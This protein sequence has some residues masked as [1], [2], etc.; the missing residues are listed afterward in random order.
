[1]PGFS[2]DAIGV[3][4]GVYLNGHVLEVSS[5]ITVLETGILGIG[6]GSRIYSG[7][8]SGG[9]GAPSWD[10]WDL[11]FGEPQADSG[12]FLYHQVKV[13]T[14]HAGRVSFPAGKPGDG[15][16]LVSGDFGVSGVACVTGNYGGVSWERGRHTGDILGCLFVGSGSGRGIR[17]AGMVSD[18][19]VKDTYVYGYQSGMSLGS[20]PRSYPRV[21]IT[22]SGSV[23]NLQEGFLLED[24]G[25]GAYTAE[26]CR[27][28]YNQGRGMDL[29]H[30]V[31]WDGALEGCHA[32]HNQAPG[33]GGAIL[34]GGKLSVNGSSICRNASAGSGGALAIL[35]DG[36]L[37]LPV[38]GALPTDWCGNY[39]AVD[40]GAIAIPG[41]DVVVTNAD[42]DLQVGR[43]FGNT[44]GNYGGFFYADT[45]T[46]IPPA[47]F[48]GELNLSGNRARTEGGGGAIYSV[49]M[50][51]ALPETFYVLGNYSGLSD[52]Q[53]DVVMKA[54]YQLQVHGTIPEGCKVGITAPKRPSSLRLVGLAETVDGSPV[55]SGYGAFILQGGLAGNSMYQVGMGRMAST[56]AV[57]VR[58][59]EGTTVPSAMVG[60]QFMATVKV[61]PDTAPSNAHI[62]AGTEILIAD[63]SGGELPHNT[64]TGMLSVPTSN[65]LK[66]IWLDVNGNVLYEDRQVEIFSPWQYDLREGDCQWVFDRFAGHGYNAVEVWVQAPGGDPTSQDPADWAVY[67]FSENQRFT[68]SGQE[69]CIPFG[70]GYTIRMVA[71]PV[72]DTRE[73]DAT[74]FDYDISDGNLYANEANARAG[75]SPL[76]ASSTVT[77]KYMHVDSQG[78]NR[79]EN[80][81]VPV[82]DKLTPRLAFGNA[83]MATGLGDL[84]LT[85]PHD[86]SKKFFF[87]KIGA[88][89][90]GN[91]S[92]D[93][94][95]KGC[96]FG[97][98]T[99][100]SDGVPVFNTGLLAPDL[101]GD[102][103]AIG[104]T[105]LTE[106]TGGKG[107]SSLTFYTRGYRNVLTGVKDNPG[108]QHLD[109]FSHPG[110]YTMWTNHFWPADYSK[111]AGAAGHDP[112]WGSAATTA[113]YKLAGKNNVTLLDTVESIGS[114][115][116]NGM[117]HNSYFGMKTSFVFSMPKGYSGPLEFMFYGDDDLW[118]FLDGQLVCDIGGVHP[119]AGEYVNFWDYIRKDDTRDHKVE[120][121]YSERGASGSTCWMQYML[122]NVRKEGELPE[123]NI[124]I[125]KE[126]GNEPPEGVQGYIED[127]SFR[128]LASVG[129][130]ASRM[131]PYVGE[132]RLNGV[133]YETVDGVMGTVKAGESILVEG[134][135]VGTVFKVE[136]WWPDGGSRPKEYDEPVVRI[137]DNSA[138]P[139]EGA[140]G[141]VTADADVLVEVENF[142]M[143]TWDFGILKYDAGSGKRLSGV[144]FTVTPVDGGWE[145]I[146]DPV[147]LT[148]EGGI[149]KTRLSGLGRWVLEEVSP[150]DG[151]AQGGPWVV[152]SNQAG[153]VDVYEATKAEGGGY[154]LGDVRRLAYSDG[155]YRFYCGNSKPE[156]VPALP[157]TGGH[158][159]LVYILGCGLLALAGGT[160]ILRLRGRRRRGW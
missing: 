43:G 144:S 59:T 62:V 14:S 22:G 7:A 134:V 158:V 49:G 107:F 147:S 53:D 125:T 105:K 46:D 34:L 93:R 152:V 68:L 3:P 139:V 75:A 27:F 48:Y 99:G 72:E 148:T 145:A 9:E 156:S 54:E 56:V 124:R 60:V 15:A 70:E 51:V 95:F 122:P 92:K 130:D 123:Q 91:I 30:G 119:S 71:L 37:Q 10:G 101:F 41:G 154:V 63:T 103:E 65:P 33:D 109:K 159:F 114:P 4:G 6:D 128:L 138:I 19:A 142:F 18:L 121:F 32:D 104:K 13:K 29:S 23:G 98:V 143:E 52:T 61:L 35:Q 129:G 45:E 157:E 131:V 76:D 100:I 146:G 115:A 117:D 112:V 39:A 84:G 135:P 126:V 153:D 17:V 67:E 111:T 83:N 140:T 57:R 86:A 66:Q 113:K 94:N 102:S 151:Y 81:P 44:A 108:A 90:G 127:F 106:E 2:M 69:G 1:M 55:Q 137:L 155:A 36:K 77:P 82:T 110:S 116:D 149:A 89:V 16:L 73:Q 96:F 120:I 42:T 21:S 87:N 118:V 133:A 58:G 8:I 150:P 64:G 5:P 132:Y 47:M 97:L 141:E 74:F 11:T 25:S 24:G 78:I 79:T 160:A 31:S 38:S 20:Q 12:A 80:L 136:E 88:Q 26:S 85:S 40:G 28:S 50:P